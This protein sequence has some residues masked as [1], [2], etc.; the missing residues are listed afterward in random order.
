MR[1]RA[2]YVSKQYLDPLDE[3][4]QRYRCA[5]GFQPKPEII[6]VGSIDEGLAFLASR[7]GEPSH[8]NLTQWGAHTQW[9]N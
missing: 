6:S 9:N 3:F 2:G 4:R 8:I 5:Q 1:R 7:F